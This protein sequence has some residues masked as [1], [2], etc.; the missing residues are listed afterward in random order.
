MAA[1]V[2]GATPVCILEAMFAV[3]W[4]VYARAAMFVG[5][6]NIMLNGLI[7][8]DLVAVPESPTIGLNAWANLAASYIGD[9]F[10]PNTKPCG[11]LRVNALAKFMP[12]TLPVDGLTTP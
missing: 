5:A 11:S 6:A 4:A 12:D 7:S 9:W 1:S 2:P 3:G 8:M 10:D